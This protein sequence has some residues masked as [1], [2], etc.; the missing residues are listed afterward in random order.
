VSL[1][2]AELNALSERDATRE[3]AACCGSSRWIMGMAA[4]RPFPSREAVLFAADEVWDG[5]AAADWL[6]AFAHHPR[7]GEAH[8]AAASPESERWAAGEQSRAAEADAG[9]KRE[10]AAAQR[11]YEE[12]FG[13]IFLICAT[14]KTAADI[15]AA[16]R[17]RMHNDADTELRV[18]A[19]EQRQITRLR[20]EKLLS[21]LEPAERSA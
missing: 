19:D 20:L 2:V 18:A 17:A 8:A 16:A 13:H 11:E 21:T 6:E 3:L 9:V 7:I 14:G 10:L 1:S 5:L 4:R 12:R 15:L